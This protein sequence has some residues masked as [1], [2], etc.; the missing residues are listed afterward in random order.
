MYIK[1]ESYETTLFYKGREAG[2]L[3]FQLYDYVDGIGNT[4][5]L[6]DDIEGL[7]NRPERFVYLDLINIEP[8]YRRKGLGTKAIFRAASL[9]QYPIF[10]KVGCVSKEEYEANIDDVKNYI[11][12]TKVPFYERNGFVDMSDTLLGQSEYVVMMKLPLPFAV[13][14]IC[15]PNKVH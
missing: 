6:F 8:E 4:E 5:T 1:S 15:K 9:G 10:A 13:D 3:K 2:I 14:Y 11:I 12:K 7:A